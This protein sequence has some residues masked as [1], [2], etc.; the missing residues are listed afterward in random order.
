MATPTPTTPTDPTHLTTWLETIPFSKSWKNV[1]RDFSD[2]VLLAEL[3]SHFF[4]KLIELHNYTPAFGANLKRNNWELL[5]RKVLPKLGIKLLSETIDGVCQAKSGLIETV[6]V[7]E[8]VFF[9]FLAKKPESSDEEPIL[10]SETCLVHILPS[11]AVPEFVIYK[12]V[13]FIPQDLLVEKEKSNA[14]MRGRV[15][16]LAQKVQRLE[17][18][19]NLKETHLGDL[20]RQIHQIRMQNS[21]DGFST[22]EDSCNKGGGDLHQFLGSF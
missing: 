16:E 11:A 9:Y 17:T 6:I 18:L 15:R 19:I 1:P 8:R 10:Q 7:G 4:P 12:G 3:I 21:A 5:N 14:E 20:T 22:T 13:K 2:G